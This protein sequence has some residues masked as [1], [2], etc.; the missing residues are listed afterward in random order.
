MKELT[1]KQLVKLIDKALADFRGNANEVK[2]A[3]GM[4]MMGRQ[5][6]WKVMLLIHDKKT[7]RKYEEILGIDIRE[8]MPEVGPLAHK[9]IAW[10]AAQ[11]I[12]NFWKA[13]KGE[14]PGIRTPELTK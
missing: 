4:L 5:Y 7:I 10:V 3:I 13:V 9:S 14:I 12:S 11:K 2:G 1:D 6:G 8:V